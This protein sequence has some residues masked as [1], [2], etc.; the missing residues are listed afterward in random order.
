[1]VN[2]NEHDLSRPEEDNFVPTR[3]DR[4]RD[5]FAN[6]G[7]SLA[8]HKAKIIGGGIALLL[9]VGAVTATILTPADKVAAERAQIAQSPNG[10]PLPVARAAVDG[11]QTVATDETNSIAI[12]TDASKGT[13][14]ASP[15]VS[16]ST[17]TLPV[18]MGDL[19]TKLSDVFDKIDKRFSD[20]AANQLQIADKLGK[21]N[22]TLG[23]VSGDVDGL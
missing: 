13:P 2:L 15:T 1:M 21:V 16:T 10:L 23:Q 20:S 17:G 6:S 7:A 4:A 11:K 8:A 12:K 3:M 18:G 9:G 19:A 22:E 5:F 14:A